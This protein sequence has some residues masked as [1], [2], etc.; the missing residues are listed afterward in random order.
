MSDYKATIIDSSREL[1][2]IERLRLKD[3]SAAIALDEELKKV[4]AAGEKYLEISPVVWA[5]VSVENPKSSNPHYNVYV[6]QQEDG[7]T[8]TTSSD[9]FWKSFGDIVSELHQDGLEPETV[10][11]YH[12]P[13][14]NYNGNILLCTI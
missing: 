3:T 4:E 10:K 6:L 2:A 13:S 7:T 11:A 12:T 14:K 1:T 5:T 8:Y 9:S